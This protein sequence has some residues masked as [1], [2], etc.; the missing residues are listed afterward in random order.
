M[1]V[2]LVVSLLL[3]YRALLTKVRDYWKS[4]A[5]PL[6]LLLNTMIYVHQENDQLS[7]EIQKPDIYQRAPNLALDN[8]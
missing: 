7:F 5:P 8:G 6:L 3:R 2:I 4:Y 1:Q